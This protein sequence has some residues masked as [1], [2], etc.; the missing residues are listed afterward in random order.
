MLL[1]PSGARSILQR[2]TPLLRRSRV[3]AWARL[4]VAGADV[5]HYRINKVT[6][7][8]GVILKKKDIL[9]SSDKQ[10]VEAAAD[11]ADCPTCEV[12]R[13]GQPV[14]SVT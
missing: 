5:R 12:L 4:V 14:G 3:T 11:S 10:A 8:G 13:D 1:N 9:A 2:S 6:K 7:L